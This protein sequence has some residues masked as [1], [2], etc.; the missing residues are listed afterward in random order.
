LKFYYLPSM[1]SQPSDQGNPCN[2]K[3]DRQAGDTSIFPP[4]LRASGTA[5]CDQA[6]P[7]SACDSDCDDFTQLGTV[8]IVAISY[9]A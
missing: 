3:T 5:A 1:D 2:V 6:R 7:G 4:C 9:H 8:L